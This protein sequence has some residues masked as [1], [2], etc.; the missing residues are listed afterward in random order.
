MIIDADF[1][2]RFQLPIILANLFLATFGYYHSYNKILI[3]V[4]RKF[5]DY[6]GILLAIYLSEGRISSLF[7]LV[8]YCVLERETIYWCNNIYIHIWYITTIVLQN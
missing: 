8:P 1:R 5:H 2:C 4:E 6:R 7:S 3:H